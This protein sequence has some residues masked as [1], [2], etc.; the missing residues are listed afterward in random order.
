MAVDEPRSILGALR[1]LTYDGCPGAAAA[2]A[3]RRLPP[4]ACRLPPPPRRRGPPRPPAR[5]LDVALWDWPDNLHAV[6]ERDL[7]ESHIVHGAGRNG[8]CDLVE[9]ADH[10]RRRV[11]I[12]L[13]A[14]DSTDSEPMRQPG[15]DVDE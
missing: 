5:P 13:A 6:T 11:Q 2:A 15:R 10:G 8:R 1:F 7:A 14:G 9:V 12:E 4:A 3:G